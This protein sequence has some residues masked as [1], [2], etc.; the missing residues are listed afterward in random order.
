MIDSITQ[1]SSPVGIQLPWVTSLLKQEFHRS[2]GASTCSILERRAKSR[3]IIHFKLWIPL[4]KKRIDTIHNTSVFGFQ[5]FKDLHPRLIEAKCNNWPCSVDPPYKKK[6]LIMLSGA[7]KTAYD[8]GVASRIWHCLLGSA[9][10]FRNHSASSISSKVC[11]YSVSKPFNIREHGLDYTSAE[12][13][14]LSMA[15]PVLISQPWSRNTSR[16][17][18]FFS[19]VALANNSK[20]IGAPFCKSCE[21]WPTVTA[22]TNHHQLAAMA[23]SYTLHVTLLAQTHDR[24]VDSHSPSRFVDSPLLQTWCSRWIAT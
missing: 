3:A 8:K 16:L 24:T 12:G 21:I 11:L 22:S 10:C 19:F 2:Q 6:R 1:C 7:S 17:A 14:L 4:I 5:V 18:Y 23:A 13:I 9:P 15:D 20:F